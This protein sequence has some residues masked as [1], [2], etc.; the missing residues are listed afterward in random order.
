MPQNM[1]LNFLK[2]GDFHIYFNMIFIIF[3]YLFFII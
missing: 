1:G 2:A 3:Y